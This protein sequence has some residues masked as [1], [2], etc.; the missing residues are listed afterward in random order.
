MGW[1]SDDRALAD[2]ATFGA[3]RL[4]GEALIGL[5]DATLSGPAPAT[6]AAPAVVASAPTP[7]AL[8]TT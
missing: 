8:G 6:L 5:L 1:P 3:S 2:I 4:V 7:V